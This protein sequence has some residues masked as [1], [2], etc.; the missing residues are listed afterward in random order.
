[1][2][3]RLSDAAVRRLTNRQTLTSGVTMLI[4]GAT[5][6][7]I[8]QHNQPDASLWIAL[9]ILILLGVSVAI[10]RATARRRFSAMVLTLTGDTIVMNAPG[11][12]V[13]QQVRRDEVVRIE[14]RRGQG[15][16]V[17]AGGGRIVGV[18]AVLD[19]YDDI[20][21]VLATWHPIEPVQPANG[22]V[23]L[24]PFVFMAAFA[25]SF[26]SNDPRIVVPLGS[27]CA[28][29]LIAAIIYTLRSR[30]IAPALR[31]T[32]FVALLPLAALIVRIIIL[33]SR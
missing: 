32:M 29:G 18:P 22:L 10:G 24:L 27:L 5:A 28:I 1:M 12:L 21:A 15:L 13:P 31:V 25:V 20:R 2:E 17:R 19:A 26:G 7:L 33:V 9:P 3:Y 11:T 23:K 16:A 14:E 4:A 8:V 30:V 6:L